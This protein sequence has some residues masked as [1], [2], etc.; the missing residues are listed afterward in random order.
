MEST[1]YKKTDLGNIPED[2]EVISMSEI[3][4]NI[5][6]L[7]YSP[8]DVKTYG[9]LVLRSSNVQNGKL[10]FEDNVYVEMELPPR[11]FV[12]ENDIL[13]C[14]RNGSKQLIGKCALIDRKTAGAAFGAFMSIFRSPNSHYVF[15]QFQ[16]EIIQKQI[17]EVLGATINQ[18][19]NR[20]FASFKI[21]FPPTLVEQESI[22]EVLSDVDA[23]ITSLERLIDKKKQIKQ[24]MMQKLLTPKEGWVTKKLGE[25]AKVN[26]GQSPLSEYYNTNAN[27]LPLIQGNADIK[28]RV[29]IIRNYTSYITKKASKGDII[30][31]V[32][33]PVGEI[34]KAEF[35]CCI[36]RG[37]CAISFQNDFMYHYMINIESTWSKH[38]TGSTFDS[39]NSN[40]V[41]GL[42]ISVPINMKEQEEIASILSEMDLELAALRNKLDKFNRIKQ[43]MMQVLLTGKVRVI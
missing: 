39:V 5:T 17:N 32:R 28:N 13:I 10:A 40:L 14:V 8:K 42:E 6:G 25:V 7:T 4:Q 43:G 24:G 33:A 38:S 20:D 16:S 36:G 27:G 19:T 41:K 30:M 31:T 34:A 35:E 29:T 12:K 18:I 26:M 23:M 15:Y 1:K 22:V 37:V 9:T 3:G 21:P 11:V 2:W